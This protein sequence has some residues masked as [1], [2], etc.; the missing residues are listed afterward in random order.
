V[1]KLRTRG[2]LSLLAALLAALTTS[3]GPARAPPTEDADCRSM[4]PSDWP[5]SSKPYFL[6]AVD[7][8]G[9]MNYND[10][11]IG[12]SWDNSCGYH[13]DAED[14]T[15]EATRNDAARCAIYNTVQAYAGLVNFGL[16]AFPTEIVE[17]GSAAAS[18]NS[19]RDA[20][21]RNASDSCV[22]DPLYPGD[23]NLETCGASLSSACCDRDDPAPGSGTAPWGGS[24]Y[25]TGDSTVGL[26]KGARGGNVLVG[27]Q[28]DN[29]WDAPA[30]RVPSN[31]ADVLQ[32]VDNQ[33][34]DCVEL[35]A[36]G[37]T[38]LHGLLRDAQRYL[39]TG[40]SDP[41]DGTR[42]FTTPLTATERPCRSVNVILVTDGDEYCEPRA[43]NSNP[44]AA[45]ASN[46]AA[47]LLAGVTVG[48]NVFSVRTHVI[49]LGQVAGVDNIAYGG[50]TGRAYI[51]NNEIELS[52]ALAAIIASAVPPESCNNRDDNCNGCTDEGSKTWCNRDKTALT[53][54][55]LLDPAYVGDPGHC[56]G[57]GSSRE[58]CL[59]AFRASID[60]AT[61]PQ[62]DRWLLPCWDADTDTTDPESKWLCQNPG[63]TCDDLDN[64]CDGGVIAA[65][66]GLGA[67]QVDEGFN[68]CPACPA[69]ETC[70][71]VDDDCDLLVDNVAPPLDCGTCV[72]APEIC[73]GIDNDCDTRIDEEFADI[74]CGLLTSP[75]PAC[76]GVISC[77]EEVNPTGLPGASVG[78]SK[79]WSACSDDPAATDT[80]C[81]G[82]DDDCNGIADDGAP[83]EACVMPGTPDG[84]VYRDAEHPA[85]RCVMGHRPCVDGAYAGA[86]QGA[87]GP[88]DQEFCNGV[89]D[90]CDGL[91][92]E[93]E[94]GELLPGEGILDCGT[95]VGKCQKGTT[96]CVGGRIVC[97]GG[98][99]NPDPF[100]LCDGIDGDCDGLSD[101]EDNLDD[102]PADP[103]CWPLA[104]TSCV[105][106]D[107][108]T[109]GLAWDPPQGADCRGPG[110]LSS[111]CDTGTLRCLVDRWVC[112]GGQLPTDEVCDGI[113][114]DCNDEVDDAAFG[115]PIGDACGIETGECTTGVNACV[116]GTITCTG[117]GPT[118][119]LC[120]GLDNDCDGD[121]DNGLALGAACAVAYDAEIYPGD[122]TQ[123]E[124][125]P[126][127][128]QCDTEAG[129]GGYVCIGGVGPSPEI[130]DGKDN[131]CDGLTDEAGPAPDG[132]DG[133]V[134][135]LDTTSPARRIGDPCGVDEGLCA[136][137]RLGC[138]SGLVVCVGGVGAQA[139]TCDCADNDCDGDVDEPVVC[140]PGKSCID[141]GDFCFCLEPC[142][143]GEFPCP[144]GSQQLRLPDSHTGEVGCFC[145]TDP[146]GDCSSK[147]VRVNAVIQCAPTGS[148]PGATHLPECVCKGTAGCQSPCFQVECPEGQA[149]VPTGPATGQCQPQNSCYFFG[150][151]AGELC[152]GGACVDDPCDPNPCGATEV[153]KPNAS[154]TEARCVA[155]CAGVECEPIER[156]VEGDCVATGCAEPCTGATVCQDDGE[157]GFECG[158]S[159]CDTTVLLPCADGAY[160]DPATGACGDHPCTGVVCPEAQICELGECVAA[161]AGGQGG[162]GGQGG[163]D[164]ES[165]GGAPV[166]GVAGTAGEASEDGGDE[167]EPLPEPPRAW[168]LATGGGG[169]SCRTAPGSRSAAGAALAL[170]GLLLLERRRRRPPDRHRAAARSRRAPG[171]AR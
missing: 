92:D 72:P 110:T 30:A 32:W 144:T 78:A 5:E 29:Y 66:A 74:P 128:S 42:A 164:A 38:P 46:A 68:K 45:C 106:G 83:G 52:T 58:D 132:I 48:S 138:I 155:S 124:C 35:W 6:L 160:C 23:P 126:G 19:F 76:R 70:N 93:R 81:D 80:T 119:E 150:C 104:G 31:L 168:G 94:G 64:N 166:T 105:H 113:D 118:P 9:S 28:Q 121:T 34:G 1:H 163:G 111:P 114:N 27:I 55:A 7:T 57:A 62:G 43:G 21:G 146:C 75:N 116:A 88:L 145:F 136:A 41:T 125:H 151:D 134:D 171:G 159:R 13:S 3:V 36:Y 157:G 89:D 69:P 122:R 4:N 33:C 99:I 16:M 73:D 59:A 100:E 39:T 22:V 141:T 102:A 103:G 56:C 71:G 139:E 26:N 129:D 25:C 90:D 44:E 149:C 97:G 101:T 65:E 112:D 170:L 115:A 137:G 133:T 135:P 82:V 12:L 161:P 147:T 96:E 40:W 109:T 10:R 169:C 95:D 53:L 131:D 37:G 127:L 15:P 11:D 98:G 130:C 54:E 152:S 18:C 2:P 123:G 87:V 47:D 14:S 117:Q 156:C 20:P 17:E 63:E 154:R 167:V 153:C 61:N 50:G 24:T 162:Q 108:A 142:G 85:S 120:D 107:P 77:A 51:A 79:T 86:C 143:G 140:S 158:P 49:A 84:V 148:V 60:A 8:S 91:V 165:S 67:S